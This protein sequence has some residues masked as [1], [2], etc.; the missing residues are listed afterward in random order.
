[1]FVCLFLSSRMFPKLSWAQTNWIKSGLYFF[2]NF[3]RIFF[4]SSVGWLSNTV[5]STSADSNTWHCLRKRA[6]HTRH[7]LSS[8]ME[9]RQ[10]NSLLS[11]MAEFL[12]CPKPQALL[13]ACNSEMFMHLGVNAR[14]NPKTMERG[15]WDRVTQT[16][17]DSWLFFLSSTHAG[18]TGQGQHIRLW[19]NVLFLW[20]FFQLYEINPLHQSLCN[21]ASEPI[22]H[23][24][25][26]RVHLVWFNQS[27]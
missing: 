19:F 18:I 21:K 27:V 11:N 16:T 17:L 5:Q 25:Y 6:I 23:F 3:V 10:S 4:C 12:A 7:A 15:G 14:M 1:M 13:L 20:Y 22:N 24:Y 26:Q 8:P 2:F 9:S